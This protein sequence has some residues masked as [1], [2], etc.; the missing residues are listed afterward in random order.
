MMRT[1]HSGFTLIELVVVIVIL[2]ILAATALPKFID[3]Q[4]DARASALQ[5]VIGAA[6]SAMSINY[7]GCLTTNH[8]V[9]ANK[10]VAV[11]NCNDVSSLL[12]GG[13]PTGYT[14]EDL[15]IAAGN[16][17]TQSG[18][19]ITQEAGTVDPTADFTAIRA[20]T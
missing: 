4:G 16:G 19:T 1:Q 8:V 15:A 9:T 6:N 20:G 3:I 5:G 11:D 17:S 14:V 13:L 10:C 7:A 2:G 12:T 18:C